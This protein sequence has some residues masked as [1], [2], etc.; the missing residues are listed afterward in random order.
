MKRTKVRMMSRRVAVPG[1]ALLAAACAHF[2][3]PAAAESRVVSARPFIAGSGVIQ[4]V[5]VVHSPGSERY[6]LALQMDIGGYQ[7]LD[8]DSGAFFPDEAVEVTR[9]GR[10]TR[11]S[12]TTFNEASRR[13]RR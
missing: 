5:A 8:V 7:T 6:R 4:S 1:A 11:I 3:D 10:L 12:G 9:D 2:D 13:A